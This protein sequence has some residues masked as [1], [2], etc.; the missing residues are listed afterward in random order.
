M[1]YHFRMF[2]R[3]RSHNNSTTRKLFVGCLILLGSLVV[4]ACYTGEGSEPEAFRS[5]TLAADTTGSALSHLESLGFSYDETK[6][7]IRVSEQTRDNQTVWVVS[8]SSK[9][10]YPV[11]KVEPVTLVIDG[12][13]VKAMKITPRHPH[14]PNSTRKVVI[15]EVVVSKA[16]GRII[17]TTWTP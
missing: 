2:Y 4:A 17:E 1:N 8:I 5:Q 7:D 12:E 15:T 16:D 14:D 11:K 6:H 13:E 3:S 10:Y 9:G